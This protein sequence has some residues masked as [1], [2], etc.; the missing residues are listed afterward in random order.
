M[1]AITGR[2]GELNQRLLDVVDQPGPRLRAVATTLLI[3][4][5]DCPGE[6]GTLMEAMVASD[7]AAAMLDPVAAAASALHLRSRLAAGLE[8]LAAGHGELTVV[9]SMR[10]HLTAQVD[11]WAA[12]AVDDADNRRRAERLLA[13][14]DRPEQLAA[15]QRRGLFAGMNAAELRQLADNQVRSPVTPETALEVW[16]QVHDW[17]AHMQSQLGDG[18]LAAWSAAGGSDPL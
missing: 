13:W 11:R 7:A 3:K 12:R 8:E 17:L 1:D 14:A 9:R 15:A 16:T 4:A 18:V 6:E 5:L 10:T 2:P